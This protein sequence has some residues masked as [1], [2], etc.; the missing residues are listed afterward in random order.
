MKIKISPVSLRQR[1]Y[2]FIPFM[3]IAAMIA[4]C[5][6]SY[7]PKPAGY[8]R[9]DFPEKKYI[10]YQS[11]CNYSFDCPVYGK[12]TPYLGHGSEPC[13]INI[14][15]PAYKGKI[16]ITY[17]K[18]HN[19]LATHAEDIRTLAYKHSIKADDIQEETFS[20]PE[21]DVY[22]MIYDIRG[23]TASSMSF[24]VTDSTNNFLSGSLYFSVIPNKDS[25]APVIRFFTEDI[26]HLIETIRWNQKN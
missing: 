15:F 6:K 5:Q 16:H 11:E 25:L 22:G 21:R 24:F 26:R 10:T 3:M 1:L 18:L 20:F 14:E 7:T 13:W 17:K 9:I 23:N 4:G 19:D 12:V 2:L 8:F